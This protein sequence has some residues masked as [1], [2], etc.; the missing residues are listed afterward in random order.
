MQPTKSPL[1]AYANMNGAC[2]D[3]FAETIRSGPQ[4]GAQLLAP[5]AAASYRPDLKLLAAEEAV[6]S[7]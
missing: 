1:T 2:H 5:T 6:G 3:D 4:T 7:A